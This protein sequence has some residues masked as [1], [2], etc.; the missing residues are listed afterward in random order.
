MVGKCVLSSKALGS[1][2]THL[3]NVN[4]KLDKVKEMLHRRFF[5]IPNVQNICPLCLTAFNHLKLVR[6]MK[7]A[8]KVTNLPSLGTM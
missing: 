1:N 2:P 8:E 5:I 4:N 6:F 3:F 7:K